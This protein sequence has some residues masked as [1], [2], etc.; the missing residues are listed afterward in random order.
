MQYGLLGALEVRTD[1]GQVVAIAAP[2][3]RALL[4]ALLVYAGE[5][6]SADRLIEVLWQGQPPPAA[7]ASL[8]AHI[9]RLRRDLGA[10]QIVTTPTG[11][12]LR[13]GEGSIDVEDFE[14][15]LADG[16]A[17][18]S[19]G[20]W[21]T[22][23]TL[24]HQA[25]DLWRGPALADFEYDEFAQ[26]EITRLEE[27]RLS[28]IEERIDADLALGRHAEVIADLE[29]LVARHPTGE[30]FWAQ[31]MLALYRSGRQVD[32][33][34]AYRRLRGNLDR[35]LGIDP[36]PELQ[37]LEI[38]I[39]RQDGSLAGPATGSAQPA[40]HLPLPMSSFV[41]RRRELDQAVEVLRSH[42]LLTLT[43]PGGVGKTRLGIAVAHAMLDAA[44]DGVLFVDLSA[45]RDPSRVLAAIGELTGGGDQPFE[46][47]G[48]RRMLLVLDNL[49]QVLDSAPDVAA[50]LDRC[51]KLRVLATSRAPLR[52]RGER[53]LEVPSMSASESAALFEDRA[54]AAILSV[55][56]IE[57]VVEDI[58]GRLD[59]LPLA[60]ELAA[61]RV[62]VLS[63]EGLRDR[64]VDRLALLTTGPR[65]APERH[66]TLRETI[67]WSYGLL[68]PATQAAFRKLSVL[69][70]SFDLP[71]ALAIAETDLDSIDELVTHS[72]LRRFADRYSMLET[73]RE[74]ADAEA[75]DHGE[76]AAARDRHLAHFVKV[77]VSTHRGTTEGGPLGRNAWL[78]MC[79][80]ER[81]NLRAAF[82]RAVERD[83]D[84][85]CV[86]LFRMIGM[87][88]LLVG[89]IDEGE[90]WGSAAVAA[91]ARLGS[92]ARRMTALMTLSEFPRFGGDPERALALKLEALDLAR[93]IDRA[94]TT[95]LLDDIASIHAATGE[96]AQ[97]RTLLVEAMV[98]HDR[99]P[100]SDPLDRA[101][102]VVTL[103][104]VALLE[105]N[106]AEAERHVAEVNAIEATI[107]L[108]PDWIL[109][110]D[111]LRAKTFL[112][113]GH[114]AE[115][116]ALF[117]TVV[118]DAAEVGFRMPLVD[119][120]DGLAAIDSADRPAK[121]AHL[122]GMADRVRA[123]ARLG[124]WNE[125]QHDRSVDAAR[126]AL[127]DEAFHRL[128]AEG[129]S[130]AIPAI[131]AAVADPDA[132]AR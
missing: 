103:A 112:A 74:F 84:D 55:D 58:V 43:G 61:A 83:D 121:T 113:T 27:L 115:A 95:V 107:D 30:R 72:L 50:L 45:V 9:S 52:I 73:I 19:A 94:S 34:A 49:E 36:A 110:S 86:R 105:G 102:T 3:R 122:L 5:P 25:L 70:G 87:Y 29:T 69:A 82:S 85:S 11:Y 132:P 126:T 117:R 92:D 35:E 41:G 51:P 76:T 68:R 22:A 118:R 39:L 66:R 91:A 16:R 123:E 108:V 53:Q 97:A 106:G 28:A 125:A 33:L 8:H 96:F 63:P 32:A 98:M 65:D 59:G 4:A 114:L 131:V 6:L 71:G 57:Q 18:S 75:V 20:R 64:L 111:N 46:V 2:K 56:L 40:I 80:R 129:H 17:A 44:P 13:L 26:T 100:A 79:G 120:L 109:E 7:I 10:D 77:A 81:E 90:R 1:D 78:A 88:W 12:R 24:L 48:D 21:A 93:T 60:I 62:H 116:T 89:A 128:H 130:L 127:G 31:L 15:L 42:R 99:E 14:R 38:R 67:A 23:T 54:R 119:A 47:I 101:H 124:Y 104:E 37:E